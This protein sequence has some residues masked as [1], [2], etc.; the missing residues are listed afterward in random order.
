MSADPMQIAGSGARGHPLSI[1]HAGIVRRACSVV[2]QVEHEGVIEAERL[3]AGCQVD[4]RQE[5]EAVPKLVNKH[6]D[7]IDLVPQRFSIEAIIPSVRECAG[8]A[9]RTV[10]LGGD[11]RIGGIKIASMQSVCQ[12]HGIPSGGHRSSA[13]IT[14]GRVWTGGTENRAGGAAGQ[15]RE[16]RT[17]L[18]RDVAGDERAPDVRGV[19]E[20]DQPLLTDRCAGISPHGGRRCGVVESDPCAIGVDDRKSRCP[21]GRRSERIRPD[22]RDRKQ[23]KA[24]SILLESHRRPHENQLKLSLFLVAR[25]RIEPIVL[26]RHLAIGPNRRREWALKPS[27]EVEHDTTAGNRP[28]GLSETLVRGAERISLCRAQLR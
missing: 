11:I 26:D 13:E 8:R 18:D 14:E 1:G 25:R 28:G 22:Q 5:P 7:E 27:L 21:R 12:R 4:E 15:R 24:H 23:K 2:F 3:R 10:E 6:A 16:A 17:H 9:D 20:C 19:L